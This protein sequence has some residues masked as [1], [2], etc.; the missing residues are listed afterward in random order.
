MADG[1]AQVTQAEE[2]GRQTVDETVTHG[3]VVE[4]PTCS[5]GRE[6]NAMGEVRQAKGSQRMPG[7][8]A[9]E[10][11][12]TQPS[13]TLSCYWRAE[14]IGEKGQGTAMLPSAT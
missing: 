14:I 3:S 5:E 8:K 13:N 12:T 10:L 6:R 9:E 11:P 4:G 1:Y 7:Q 2:Q